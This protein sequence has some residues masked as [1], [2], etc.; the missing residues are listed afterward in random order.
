MTRYCINGTF[1]SEK[2][3]GIFRFAEEIIKALDSLV[4]DNLDIVLVVPKHT[5]IPFSLKNIR[6]L[7]YGFLKGIPWEQTFF[8][9]YAVF[10]AL[11]WFVV[12]KVALF[13]LLDHNTLC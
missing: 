10:F 4:G 8:A 9:F 6:I 11:V 12:K 1:L 7:E 3:T 13:E 2:R 5:L